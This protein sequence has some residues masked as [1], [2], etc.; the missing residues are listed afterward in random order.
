VLG[1]SPL[2]WSVILA[3]VVRNSLMN[4]G[5]PIFAAF[6]MEQVTPTERATLSAAMSVLWQVGWVIG[7]GWYALLQAT[8]GYAVNFITVI[9]LYTIA[10]IL[11]W[12]WFRDADRRAL[13]ARRA[14]P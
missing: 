5:N 4:A 1:F 9:T 6:A 14:A 11:Y 3:M 8:L 7:G 10:T 12:N 13:E 2:L